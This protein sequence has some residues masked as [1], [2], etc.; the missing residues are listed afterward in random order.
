MKFKLTLM[1][2]FTFIGGMKLQA[3]FPAFNWAK[4][5]GG[6]TNDYV[7]DIC[8]DASGNILMAC[9]IN[10]ANLA[11]LAKYDAV[12]NLLWSKSTAGG[13]AGASRIATDGNGNVFVCGTFATATVVFDNTT[14][15]NSF[16][17]RPDA[18][19]VKYDAAGNF[20]WAQSF[21]GTQ[22]EGCGISV[23]AAGN[24]YLALNSNSDSIMINGT[25]YANSG[26]PTSDDSFL[27]K[28]DAN[29]NINW[30]KLN[31]GS[32]SDTYTS[33]ATDTVG[34]TYVAGRF[35][36]PVCTIG[37]GSLVLTNSDTTGFSSTDFYVAKYNASGNLIWARQSFGGANENIYGIGI[38][39][40]GEIAITGEMLSNTL[41]LGSF[42][43][44]KGPSTTNIVTAKLDSAGNVLWLKNIDASGNSISSALDS[45]GNVFIIGG[46]GGSITFDNI[47]LT[48]TGA[49]YDI[50][51]TKFDTGGNATV[52]ERYGSNNDDYA[53]KIIVAPNGEFAFTGNFKG[54]SVTFGATTLNNAGN[55]TYDVFLVSGI[56]VPTSIA[57]GGNQTKNDIVVSPNPFLN[58]L[59]ATILS[60]VNENA[61]LKILDVNGKIIYDEKSQLVVGTNEINLCCLENLPAGIYFLRISSSQ[62]NNN[63]KLIKY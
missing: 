40:K 24:F 43:V 61:E 38:N 9:Y 27:I 26:N 32:D 46:F 49:G 53:P 33:I 22:S 28:G 7:T 63:I 12:G 15:T 3:Q 44:T 14:L 59:S 60:K 51:I 35:G 54:P 29:G 17:T 47:T 25:N 55:N 50:F 11:F 45:S 21:G 8:N 34:N 41:T 42:L 18:F 56:S 6:S 57:P 48:N 39:Y 62:T 30:V 36:S 20:L 13:I 4:S 16:P 19:V 58:K 31:T 52:A 1:V 2:L 23:D 5:E 10:T 37:S